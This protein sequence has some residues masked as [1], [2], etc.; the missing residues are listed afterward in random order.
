MARQL[1]E[2]GVL[3]VPFGQQADLQVVNSCTV[4]HVGDRKSRQLIRQAARRHPDGYLLVAGCYAEL[5]PKAVLSIDGVDAVLGN[6]EKD[7]LVGALRRRSLRVG[8]D[9]IPLPPSPEG[10][11]KHFPS[12]VGGEVGDGPEGGPRRTRAFV[13]IQDGCDNR[14]SYCVVP[15]ARGHQRSRPLEDILR[16][17]QVLVAEGYREVVLTGVNITS[18]GRDYIHS[19][20]QEAGATDLYGLLRRILAETE[21]Q[22]LRLSSLQPED[23]G[24][25]FYDLWESGR[26]CR[27][28]HLSLQSG[29]GAVL[30]RMRRRYNLD[31]YADLVQGARRALPGVAIT[32]DVIVG[33]PGESEAE[34]SETEQFLRSIGFAGLHVFKYS[35]RAGTP[36]AK[37]AGQVAPR[38]KQERSQRLIDLGERMAHEFRARLVGTVLSVLW[39]E[40][41]SGTEARR[42][43][44]GANGSPSSCW[45]GLSDSYVRVYADGSP[46]LKGMIS[47]ARVER[48]AGE[49]VV[50]TTLRQPASGRPDGY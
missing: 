34:Q 29:S 36:A 45:M 14:C 26:L 9:L 11:G 43:G 1:A 15:A 46:D 27:H 35:S 42:V 10:R 24:P 41:L 22:R 50:G 6:D 30:E 39:E 40:P 33:F 8:H 49:G 19:H 3:L 20:G 48:L 16:E 44:L 37:M 13:K 17:L 31:G 5:E 18:Y 25:R 21:V 47:G 28:L 12:P 32:T 38:V 7:Q 2:A 4:T 23:W